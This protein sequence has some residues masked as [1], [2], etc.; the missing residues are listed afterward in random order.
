MLVY[1]LWRLGL[2]AV[3]LGLG[4]VAGLRGALL[5]V[6]ALLVSGLLSWFLLQRQRVA[7]GMAV[8]RTV[9]RSRVRMS[10]RTAAED[11]Y[12][13]AVAARTAA[14]PAADRGPARSDGSPQPGQPAA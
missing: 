12:A 8:E 3:C 10:A 13:D 2:L 6:A 11:A 7:M 9:E 5:I 14:Q 4:W 1:N